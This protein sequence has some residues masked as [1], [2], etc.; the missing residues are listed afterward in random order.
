MVRIKTIE[1]LAMSPKFTAFAAFV[2]SQNNV[3]GLPNYRAMDLMDIPHHVPNIFVIDVANFPE[4]LRIKF[5][6]TKI[7]NFYGKNMSGKC[8]IDHYR[9]EDKFDEIEAIFWESIR[10]KAPGYTRRS[11]HLVNENVDRFKV[12]ETLLFPCTSDC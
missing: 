12:A 8:P 10:T 1:Q 9:G 11:V 2:L 4:K 5:C 7:D 3:D 6:G